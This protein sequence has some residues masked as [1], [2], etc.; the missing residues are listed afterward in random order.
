MKAAAYSLGNR[1][2]DALPRGDLV[3]QADDLAIIVLKAKQ[4]TQSAGQAI[5]HVDFP[6]DAVL[7]IVATMMS[8]ATIEV[9][10]VGSERF[11]EAEAALNSPVSLRTTFCQVEGRVGRM[12]IERFSHR[13][14]TSETFAESMA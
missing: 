4:A 7:S 1:R 11:L 14:R 12:T 8:G 3:D 10:T 9:G 2:L 6:I 5:H 13:M